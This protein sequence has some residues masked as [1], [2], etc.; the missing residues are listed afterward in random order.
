MVFKPGRLFHVF[1]VVVFSSCCFCWAW[2][3]KETPAVF[4]TGLPWVWNRLSAVL[5]FV[6]LFYIHKK[7][8]LY[9]DFWIPHLH[10]EKKTPTVLD[11]VL[12]PSLLFPFP[13]LSISL[14]AS[15]LPLWFIQDSFQFSCCCFGVCPGQS[16]NGSVGEL[17]MQVNLVSHPGTGEH[18]VSVKGERSLI[19]AY[20]LLYSNVF[21]PLN[22]QRPVMVVISFV[23][24]GP[25]SEELLKVLE[26]VSQRKIQTT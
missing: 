9:T 15:S 6:C 17:S 25:R 16:S 1:C 24:R 23:L 4:T 2:S 18:K 22:V 19:P 26:L 10:R 8:C 5:L 11:A 13:D 3:Q 21:I 12:I 14:P 7:S 20:R